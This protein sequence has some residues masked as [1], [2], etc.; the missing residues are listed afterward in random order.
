MNPKMIRV[1]SVAGAI[2]VVILAACLPRLQG[3]AQKQS[4]EE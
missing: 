4:T 2:G 3:Q 1:N